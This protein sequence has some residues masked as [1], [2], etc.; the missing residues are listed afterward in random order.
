MSSN[1]AAAKKERSDF[2]VEMNSEIERRIEEMETPGY[3][4]GVRFSKGNK[5]VAGIIIGVSFIL[6][7]IGVWQ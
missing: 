7:I 2:E 4:F 1:S 3:D 6:L 5:I